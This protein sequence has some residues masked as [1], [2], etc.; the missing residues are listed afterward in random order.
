MEFIQIRKLINPEELIN[1]TNRLVDM[2]F[3][4]LE[5]LVAVAKNSHFGKAAEECHVSQSALSLQIQK[6]EDELGIQLLERTS[7]RVVVTSCGQEIVRRAEELLRGRQE[8]VDA[9]LLQQGQF[10]GQVWIGAIPTVAPYLFPEV[11]KIFRSCCP[12]SKVVFDE[13]VTPNL[14]SK[15]SS[16]EVDVGILATP[17]EDS[18]LDEVPLFEESFL[19]A[20]PT[21]HPFGRLDAVTPEKLSGEQLLLLKDTH[22]L[23]EQVKGFCSVHGIQSSVYSS[24]TSI[25][26]L[27]ALVRAGAGITMVP[28]MAIKASK[29]FP[30]IRYIP[31]KPAPTRGIR[32]VYRRTSKLGHAIVQALQPGFDT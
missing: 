30:G 32:L 11:Q 18:L 13:E 3:R 31:I 17:T 25:T 10:P 7:R 4:E 27:L 16:G 1:K 15:I 29:L 22:C 9:A 23:K 12:E 28:E 20:V 21:R 5:Y 2:N 6:L 19:L 24:A 8:L 26:T 14:L